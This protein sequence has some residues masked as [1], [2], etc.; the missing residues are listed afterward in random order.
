MQQISEK[1]QPREGAAALPADALLLCGCNRRSG[2]IDSDREGSPIP[3]PRSVAETA[4]DTIRGVFEVSDTRA[5][6]TSQ[7]PS[8]AVAAAAAA[9]VL[10]TLRCDLRA[11]C[12]SAPSPLIKN[13]VSGPGHSHLEMTQVGKHMARA[14]TFQ[15][16]MKHQPDTPRRGPSAATADKREEGTKKLTMVCT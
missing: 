4:A 14:L 12:S 2:F 6:S 10:A 9:T 5:A 1:C 7:Q 15:K 11:C 3:R 16:K 8:A 13:F